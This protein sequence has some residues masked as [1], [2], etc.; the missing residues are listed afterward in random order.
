MLLQVPRQINDEASAALYER[1][2]LTISR[3]GQARGEK[4]TAPWLYRFVT[5]IG[6]NG[7]RRRLNIELH[8]DEAYYSSFECCSL[9][10]CCLKRSLEKLWTVYTLNSLKVKLRCPFS[11]PHWLFD[12]FVLRYSFQLAN[13]SSTD[14]HYADGASYSLPNSDWRGLEHLKLELSAF[15]QAILLNQ[16]T[17][18]ARAKFAFD[19]IFPTPD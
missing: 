6:L 8:L 9:Y 16:E 2:V 13:D 18:Y 3:D 7:R 19:Y 12:Q 15:C 5:H 4:E 14:A 11:L 17:K 1:K 10:Q